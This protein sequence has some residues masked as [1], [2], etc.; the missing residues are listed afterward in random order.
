M[1][2]VITRDDV[3]SVVR[4]HLLD[5]VEDLDPS[6]INPAL[7]MRDLGAD[8]LDLVE[9]VSLSMRELQVKVPRTQLAKLHS[10]GELVDLLYAASAP[11]VG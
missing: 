8:S 3:F 11:T 1:T 9:V 2:T 10:I 5:C 7:S 6:E 4:K